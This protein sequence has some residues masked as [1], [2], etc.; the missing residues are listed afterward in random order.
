MQVKYVHKRGEEK[1]R[2]RG[3][4]KGEGLK[5]KCLDN[6]IESDCLEKE[7]GRE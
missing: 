3:E 4:R 6:E 1:K 7:G 2:M 5:I